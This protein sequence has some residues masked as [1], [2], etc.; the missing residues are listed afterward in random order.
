MQITLVTET[1]IFCL[2]G[3]PVMD[4]PLSRQSEINGNRLTELINFSS[5]LLISL[6]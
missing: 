5:G 6:S 3:K 1:D 2:T 4:D